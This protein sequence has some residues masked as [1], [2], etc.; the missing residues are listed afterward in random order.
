MNET[1]KMDRPCTRKVKGGH[2]ACSTALKIVLFALHM[3]HY[4]TH[5]TCNALRVVTCRLLHVNDS[6]RPLIGA[7]SGGLCMVFCG[8][9]W[10]FVF[11]CIISFCRVC[12][13]CNSCSGPI[14]GFWTSF[15][16]LHAL[17]QF[18]CC[19]FQVIRNRIKTFVSCTFYPP[20]IINIWY[21]ACSFFTWVIY[22][23]LCWYY[24]W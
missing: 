2:H 22:I 13:Y 6:S 12:V 1:E 20:Q 7:H 21:S 11:A 16:H 3:K 5:E 19:F 15:A 9:G 23:T 18:I 14:K 4:I 10:R 8:R 17:F 24:C